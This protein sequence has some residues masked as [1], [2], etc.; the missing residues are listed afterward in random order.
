MRIVITLCPL[1]LC[2]K[3]FYLSN[4][5]DKIISKEEDFMFTNTGILIIIIAL[6]LLSFLFG[7]IKILL[8]K[9]FDFDSQPFLWLQYS[10]FYMVTIGIYLFISFKF[11]PMVTM[12][13]F[14]LLTILGIVIAEIIVFYFRYYELESKLQYTMFLFFSTLANGML[15]MVLPGFI[16]VISLWISFI[17]DL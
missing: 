8:N 6:L 16:V 7:G 13:S 1:C 9:F 4:N 5:Y 11:S 3:S 17:S 15:L 12:L 2:V 10:L 14:Q